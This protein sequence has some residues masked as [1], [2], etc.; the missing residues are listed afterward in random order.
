MTGLPGL[1]LRSSPGFTLRAFSPGLMGRHGCGGKLRQ[2]VCQD[3][4]SVLEHLFEIVGISSKD[5]DFDFVDAMLQNIPEDFLFLGC[6]FKA[7]HIVSFVV[8]AVR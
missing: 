7:L 6:E 5:F 3:V 1:P 4:A 8:M 2:H